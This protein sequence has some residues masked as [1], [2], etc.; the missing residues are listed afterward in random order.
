LDTLDLKY[1]TKDIDRIRLASHLV[2]RKQISLYPPVKKVLSYL[3]QNYTIVCISNISDGDLARED[4][5][6]FGILDLFHY[7]LMSS[8]LGI[9]KPSPQIF[10]HV[11]ERYDLSPGEMAFI[12]D[13]LYDDI[14]GAKN[15]DLAMAIHVKRPRSYFFPDYRIEPDLTISSLKELIPLF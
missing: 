15:A 2:W 5:A 14:Q 10:Q 4:M 7:V 6:H 12:G 13:T 3:K 8:D 9:R 1:T 11:L